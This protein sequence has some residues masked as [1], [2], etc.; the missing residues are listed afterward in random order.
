ML[1]HVRIVLQPQQTMA[2]AMVALE[3]LY[4]SQHRQLMGDKFVRIR[5]NLLR[6]VETAA[7][8]Q[9]ISVYAMD[10]KEQLYIT[11]LQLSTA[12]LHAVY[13]LQILMVAHIVS[14]RQQI[15]DPVTVFQ[16]QR[17]S[18]PLLQPMAVNPVS[19]LPLLFTDVEIAKPHLRISGHVMEAKEQQHT[20]PVQ[21]PMAGHV[22]CLLQLLKTV[23]TARQ[24]ALLLAAAWEGP[25]AQSI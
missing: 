8:L 1:T 16:E 13:R 19:Q 3:Q 7:L 21:S 9:P 20:L 2:P 4:T 18:S 25:E 24:L 10:H 15:Q 23:M 12:A 5:L 6:L 22:Q 11:Q 14:R 17:H